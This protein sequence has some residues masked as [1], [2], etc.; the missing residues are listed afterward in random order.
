MIDLILKYNKQFE[1]KNATGVN[2][3]HIKLR[4]YVKVLL[5]LFLN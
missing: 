2:R 1:R 4:S 3:L 5:T